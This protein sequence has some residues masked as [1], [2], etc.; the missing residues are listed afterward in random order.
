VKYP[1]IKLETVDI[2][3]VAGKADGGREDGGGVRGAFVLA[4]LEPGL[5]EGLFSNHAIQFWYFL[6]V[7]GIEIF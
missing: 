3:R 6:E 5:P 4:L 7:F 1:N 2:G